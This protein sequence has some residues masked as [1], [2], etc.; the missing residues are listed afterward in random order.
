MI[1]E[2]SALP[3]L[4]NSS[5]ANSAI[6]A[7]Q[8]EQPSVS[9]PASQASKP[10]LSSKTLVSQSSPKKEKEPLLQPVIESPKNT[11]QS[12]FISP[13]VVESILFPEPQMSSNLSDMISTFETLRKKSKCNISFF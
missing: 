12:T 6:S 4:K 8:S 7:S 10:P 3:A 2:F 1:P 5:G 11:Q 9:V 13:S